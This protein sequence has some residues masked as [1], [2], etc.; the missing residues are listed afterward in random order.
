MIPHNK[1]TLGKQEE[2]AAKRIIQSGWLAEGTEVEKFENNFCDFI[3]ISHGHAV[4]V[5]SGTSALY[6]ALWVLNAKK[7]KV[8]FPSYVCA[9]LRYA[10][11]M[12]QAKEEIIDIEN[13]NPNISINELNNSDCS[14]AIVPHIYGNP[15]ELD[16]IKNKLIIE[17]CCQSIGAKFNGKHV[18]LI[19]EIGIFSFFATKLMT[20]GG[21]GGMIV[22]KNI[23]LIDEIRDYREFDMRNDKKMRFNF[24]MTDLQASIGIEQLKKLP[25][26]LIRREEIFNM[27]LNAGLPIQRNNNYVSNSNPIRYRAILISEKPKELIKKL[28]ENRIKAIVPIEDW[29]LLSPTMNAI[30]YCKK[31]VSLPLYPSLTNE[32]VNYIIKT[33]Q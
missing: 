22:S 26:F 13:D 6:L 14:I 12:A 7:K 30:L 21:Q 25:S 2:L 20:S 33:I 9:S 27:Y 11:N 4:A 17:D 3:G 1:P 28:Y 19:G 16:K 24:Q 31:T 18:G 15:V 29:E 23:S 5:S 8:S 10:V 32:E